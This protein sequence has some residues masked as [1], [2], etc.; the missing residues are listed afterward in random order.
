MS[1]WHSHIGNSDKRA[2]WSRV[3]VWRE[4][5]DALDCGVRVGG[6]SDDRPADRRSCL[7]SKGPESPSVV[8]LSGGRGGVN[9]LL[10]AP[11]ARWHVE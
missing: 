8:E 6:I 3:G 11:K 7:A 9:D 1:A 2:A 4:G 5:L 10:R